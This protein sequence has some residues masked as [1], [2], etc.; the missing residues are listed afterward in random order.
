MLW[1]KSPCH[2]IERIAEKDVEAP[3][4]RRLMVLYISPVM[5]VQP[6]VGVER[7]LSVDRNCG[8]CR[9]IR[10]LRECDWVEA[11]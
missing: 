7:R 4:L 3:W 2:G 5:G 9:I 1:G 8:L 10:E 6:V 11:C